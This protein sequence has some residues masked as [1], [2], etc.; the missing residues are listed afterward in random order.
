ML[1]TVKPEKEKWELHFKNNFLKSQYSPKGI[2]VL[3]VCLGD[4][5]CCFVLNFSGLKFMLLERN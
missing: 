4:G 3:F 5:F 2:T 1:E